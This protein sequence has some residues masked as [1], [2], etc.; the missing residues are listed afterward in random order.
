MILGHQKQWKFLENSYKLGRLSHA[1]L[2]YGPSHIGKKTLAIEF[3]KFLNCLPASATPKALQAGEKE[4]NKPCGVCRNCRDIEKGI[5]P[6]FTLL[7]P[8]NK[9]MKIAQLR[10]LEYYFS[11]SPSRSLFK[12]AVIDQAHSMTQEAQNSFLKTL[13]EPKGRALFILITEYPDRI[14]PTI[15]S[16]VQ[17]IKFSLVDKSE[18]SAEIKEQSVPE[19]QIEK[20]V[21]FS[22]GRPGLALNFLK[23]PKKLLEIEQR[24]KDFNKL[25]QFDLFARFQYVQELSKQEPQDIKKVLSI[26]SRHIRNRIINTLKSAEQNPKQKN[27][28]LIQLQK[29]IK[30]I[31]KLQFS[32]ATTNINTR[33]ALETLML[34]F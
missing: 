33:L 25:S 26:W 31:S 13:E 9:E 16:R 22:L 18:I 11:L 2:F 8:D 19:S 4:S 1:Y 32:F 20:I 27:Y 24:V 28:S 10:K 14:L 21:D 23:D 15:L 17:K 34:E 7:K 6:D 30:T 12:T 5:F 3:I 29:I